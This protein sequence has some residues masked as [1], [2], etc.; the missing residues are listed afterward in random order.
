MIEGKG[1]VSRRLQHKKAVAE[2]MENSVAKEAKPGQKEWAKIRALQMNAI[3]E[4]A[5]FA[6]GKQWSNHDL[7]SFLHTLVSESN[8]TYINPLF[9]FTAQSD[10]TTALSMLAGHVNEERVVIPLW[11]RNH[12]FMAGVDALEGS[13]SFADSE[14][15]ITT[16][17]DIR[18]IT[19]F[20][21]HG[22]KRRGLKI[23]MLRTFLQGRGTV[24]CGL[25]TA[26][27]A[28][29]WTARMLQR[30]RHPH[31]A[32]VINFDP[33]ATRIAMFVEGDISGDKLL[34]AILTHLAANDAPL[35]QHEDVLETLDRLNKMGIGF[36]RMG[37][38][39]YP[40]GCATLLEWETE[41]IKRHQSTWKVA[42]SENE[43]PVWIPRKDI[44]YM[45][46]LADEAKTLATTHE[47]LDGSYL[48]ELS[49]F[50]HGQME[51]DTVTC[52]QV[53]NWLKASKPMPTTQ[54]IDKAIAATTKTKHRQILKGIQEIPEKYHAD[55]LPQALA[56][57]TKDQQRTR[58]WRRS[59][60]LTRMASI[61]GALRLAPMYRNL[62]PSIKLKD[63]LYWKLVMRAATTEAI[64]EI[65]RQPKAAQIEEIT[66]LLKTKSPLNPLLEI[67]W[68]TAAR[69]GDAL[70]L[71]PDDVSFPDGKIMNVRFRRG[72]TASKTGQ[73][74][75]AQPLPSQATINFV[76]EANRENR[77]WLFPGIETEQ[78]TA[79]LRSVNTQL[80]CRSLRRGRLQYLSKLGYGDEELLH[81]SRHA[82]LPMLRRYLTFGF[83]SGENRRQAMRITELEQKIGQPNGLSHT[84]KAPL[85]QLQVPTSFKES[86]PSSTSGS[87]D[88]TDFM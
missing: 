51:G 41:L 50:S 8:V 72:K 74:T 54:P 82:G 70:Y 33:I 83:D 28:T 88:S 10:P 5:V 52:A 43:T 19:T 68:L 15:A 58:R 1:L 30:R 59:T 26:V 49:P 65:P 38:I 84:S 46:V 31:K 81:V 18:E 14:D 27:N 79:H 75:I 60:L 61:Q 42:F 62:I 16:P 23:K 29:L 55:L 63:S 67:S 35:L 21:E 34:K 3:P 7:A 32:R 9:L 6:S 2:E 44:L 86:S 64:A 71:S 36:A 45:Y 12:W 69:V 78:L 11:I 13:I 20:I 25:H 24:T 87:D 40:N 56:K 17:E 22:L 76:E 73:Y 85:R 53:V 47:D 57:W 77:L 39:A 4:D 66:K 48:N 80:E 37:W